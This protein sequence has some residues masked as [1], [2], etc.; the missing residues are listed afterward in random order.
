MFLNVDNIVHC[1]KG[2]VQNNV[3]ASIILKE[4]ICKGGFQDLFP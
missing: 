1:S 2:R 4:L 3:N